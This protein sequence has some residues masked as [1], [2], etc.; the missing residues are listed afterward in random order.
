[1]RFGFA[2]SKCSDCVL[3]LCWLLGRKKSR[4]SLKVRA[5]PIYGVSD[6]CFV[7]FYFIRISVTPWSQQDKTVGYFGYYKMTYNALFWNSQSHLDQQQ[8]KENWVILSGNSSRKLHHWSVVNMPIFNLD[9][10]APFDFYPIT[11]LQSSK[12]NDHIDS[13]TDGQLKLFIWLHIFKYMKVNGALGQ[14]TACAPNLRHDLITA[15]F[16]SVIPKHSD[17]SIM[18]S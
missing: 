8:H 15:K 10:A 13:I 11:N 14:H 5:G 2:S 18:M 12:N 17:R 9:F 4:I 16:S 1:M 3:R 6:F 7:L